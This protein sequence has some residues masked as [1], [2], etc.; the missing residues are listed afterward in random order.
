MEFYYHELDKDVL[1]I[2]ADGGLDA[3]TADEFTRDIEK[4]ANLGVRKLIVDCTNLT[5]ISS[6]GISALLLTNKRMKTVGCDVKIAGV[7]SFVLDVLRLARLDAF[8]DLYP[9]VNAARLAFRPRDDEAP[10]NK[11]AS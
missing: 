11:P 3:S 4:V 6:R 5:Y 9:D 10:P 8:F 7:R 1:V 2:S